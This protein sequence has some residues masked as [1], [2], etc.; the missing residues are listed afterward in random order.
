MLHLFFKSLKDLKENIRQYI[1]FGLL[2]MFATSFIFIPIISFI[3]QR[4]IMLYNSGVVLNQDVFKI[5]LDKDNLFSLF[6]ILLLAI[7]FIFMEM[8][9]YILIAHK[10][11]FKKDIYISEAFFTALSK[12]PR[13]LSIELIYFFF[14][15]IFIIPLVELP[16]QSPIGQTVELP[17][18]FE[19][20]VE[21]NPLYT[22]LYTAIIIGLLYVIY[23]FIFTL[24]GILLRKEKISQ[25]MKHSF[26]LTKKG[27]AIN[28]GKLIV[29]NGLYIGFGVLVLYGISYIQANIN[30]TPPLAI[31]KY[32]LT[33][34]GLFFTFHTMLLTPFN[35]IFLTRLYYEVDIRGHFEHDGDHRVYGPKDEVRLLCFDVVRKSEAYM[36][37]HFRKKKITAILL[38]LFTIAFSIYT[39]LTKQGIYVNSGRDVEIIA[40]R[41]GYKT[42]PENTLIAIEEAIEKGVM[43]IEL[44]IQLTKDGVPVLHHD[45]ALTRMVGVSKRVS[46]VTY[47]ELQTY[48]IKNTVNEK[49]PSLIDAL[50]TIDKRA[51][52][53]LDLKSDKSTKKLIDA[54]VQDLRSSGMTD[55]VYI[56]SFNTN[57]LKYAREKA[58]E[59]RLGQVI[60]FFWGSLDALDVD[61]YTLHYTMLSR[62]LVKEIKKHDRLMWVWTIEDED[63]LRETLKYDI[64]GVITSDV[65]MVKNYFGMDED[66]L[67]AIDEDILID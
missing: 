11:Y 45:Y 28:I 24:H 9:I 62:D 5:V 34:S 31:K 3:F 26:R 21:S 37:S 56:Q 27:T 29:I 43:I 32:L 67:E 1:L 35:M 50:K 54:I 4:M 33:L 65:D 59:I 49:I 42:A 55:Y 46:D 25:A 10:K 44:D 39:T 53:L 18:F 52:V 41:A 64:D 40:H 14:L 38:I 6:L 23:R 2:S 20:K 22:A 63:I 60:Y 48:T 16:V 57:L 12:L 30:Y 66:Q 8:A 36:C 15:I 13:L 17:Q 58:P 7:T 47:R 19:A 51:Y 61:F